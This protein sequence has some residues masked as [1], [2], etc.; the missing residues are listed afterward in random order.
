MLYYTNILKLYYTG[1]TA[2]KKAKTI[3]LFSIIKGHFGALL[4]LNSKLCKNIQC[5]DLP[6]YIEKIY[7]DIFK[8]KS[9][10]MHV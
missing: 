5:K 9:C 7:G 2:C 8:I 4:R 1:Y 10:V 3:F 6:G